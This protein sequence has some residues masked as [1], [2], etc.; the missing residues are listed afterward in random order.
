MEVGEKDPNKG[1]E[2]AQGPLFFIRLLLMIANCIF[3]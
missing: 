1:N 3:C 2:L